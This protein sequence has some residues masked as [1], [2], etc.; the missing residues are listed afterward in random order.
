MYWT[1]RTA[2]NI[3]MIIQ[4]CNKDI[5]EISPHIARVISLFSL[6]FHFTISKAFIA[7]S[8]V[9]AIKNLIPK[10]KKEK[11]CPSLQPQW[12]GLVV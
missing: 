8:H 11:N 10:K 7:F 3:T 6:D 2:K 5:I 9:I 4:H 1:T 12:C